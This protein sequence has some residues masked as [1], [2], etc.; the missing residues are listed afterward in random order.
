M[1]HLK[2]NECNSTQEEIKRHVDVYQLVSTEKQLLGRGRGENSWSHEEGSLAFSFSSP[3][4]PHLTWQSLE[5]AVS[6]AKTIE[7]LWGIKIGLKWPNDLYNHDKKC[8]GILLKLEQPH[9]FIGVGINLQ[10]STHWGSVF[11]KKKSLNQNW[12]H[13]LA[14][15]FALNYLESFPSPLKKIEEAWTQR[16]VHLNKMV[17]IQDGEEIHSGLFNGL[18]VNGEAIVGGKSI[19]NGTLRWT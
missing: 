14:Y 2:L 4:H 3:V 6:L 9:M 5:V 8:G 17:T 16:C 19:Y 13:D 7:E 15:Q 1:K 12:A 10:P 11:D 18:G